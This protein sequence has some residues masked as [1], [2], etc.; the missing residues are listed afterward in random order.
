MK[1][2]QKEKATEKEGAEKDEAK[3]AAEQD[4]EK[5][6]LAAAQKNQYLLFKSPAQRLE[7]AL[8]MAKMPFLLKQLGPVVVDCHRQPTGHFY[9]TL[10]R[11]VSIEKDGNQLTFGTTVTGRATF[12]GLVNLKGVSL[13]GEQG[14][15][16]VDVLRS[17]GQQ[18]LEAVLRGSKKSVKLGGA[19]AKEAKAPSPSLD[20][21]GAQPA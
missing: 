5:K 11:D 17:P 16:A 10:S 13:V 7:V 15:G 8:R 18:K 4:E 19:P 21:D 12:K 20:E 2:T 6:R 1:D 3:D 9:L 14:A